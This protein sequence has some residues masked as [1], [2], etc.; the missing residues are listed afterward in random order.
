MSL[1]YPGSSYLEHRIVCTYK[2]NP[3]Y[4]AIHIQ[5]ILEVISFE[6]TEL[7]HILFVNYLIMVGFLY[8]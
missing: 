6:N 4:E 3:F 5:V 7:N 1:F 2:F 8:Y